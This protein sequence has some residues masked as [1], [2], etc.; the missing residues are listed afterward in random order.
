METNPD[1]FADTAKDYELNWPIW[2]FQAE[3]N[4]T[5]AN[6]ALCMASNITIKKCAA[7]LTQRHSYMFLYLGKVTGS[8]AACYHLSCV[9]A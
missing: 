7:F 9:E 3:D 6:F 1:Y 4:V 5:N 2:L 8:I